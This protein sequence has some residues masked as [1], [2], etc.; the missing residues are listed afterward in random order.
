MIFIRVRCPLQALQHAFYSRRDPLREKLAW[1]I[2]PAV[3]LDELVRRRFAPGS[4]DFAAFGSP[5]SRGGTTVRT[6]MKAG[7]LRREDEL[8]FEIEADAFLYRM[9]RRLVYIQVAFAQG[10]CTLG[11]VEA[12]LQGQGGLPAGLAPAHG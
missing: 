8:H 9:V 12:A 3:E 5:M 6:V 7:W 1:R 11:A 4:H 2:W 10:R